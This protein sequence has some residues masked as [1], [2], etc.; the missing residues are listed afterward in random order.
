MEGREI[1][2]PSTSF[3]TEILHHY[4]LRAV[5]LFTIWGRRGNRCSLWN[6]PSWVPNTFIPRPSAAGLC[7]SLAALTQ[8]FL[9][10]CRM[11]EA[12]NL[13]QPP[14]ATSP[15]APPPDPRGMGGSQRP[16]APPQ[17]PPPVAHSL[18]VEILKYIQASPHTSTPTRS[19]LC[20]AA[21]L[22]TLSKQWLGIFTG[23]QISERAHPCPRE[24]TPL[25]SLANTILPRPRA[26]AYK[27]LTPH[28]SLTSQPLPYH[29]YLQSSPPEWPDWFQ[30]SSEC[31]ES[32]AR[33]AKEKPPA[34]VP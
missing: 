33:P 26:P 4:L 27:E 14:R 13:S 7:E 11:Q 12:P 31:G 17:R 23:T 30:S 18:C 29:P 19:H 8:G 34:P 24:L 1:S 22:P 25:R 20:R 5:A 2:L 21:P 16:H 28:P 32:S 9:A 3:R 10:S 15:G 6:P